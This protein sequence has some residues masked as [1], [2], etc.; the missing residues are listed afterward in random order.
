VLPGLVLAFIFTGSLAIE[1]M[2][3]GAGAINTMKTN[4]VRLG[5][6]YRFGI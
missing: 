1:Y 4:I 3:V 5:V 2:F 6:N